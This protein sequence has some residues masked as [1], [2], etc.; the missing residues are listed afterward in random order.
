M[1]SYFKIKPVKKIL[2]FLSLFICFAPVKKSRAQL[3]PAQNVNHQTTLIT[4]INQGPKH[5]TIDADFVQ[6][7]TGKAAVAAAKKNGE[8]EFDINAK[9]DTSWYVSNDYYILNVNKKTRKLALAANANI[10]LVKEGSS[11]ITKSALQTLKRSYEGKL[12]KI[13]I[14]QKTVIKI[15]EIYTP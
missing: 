2:W 10:Y 9:G 6:M 1:E 5:I 15:E 11:K 12:F 7:L 14:K 8:A 4:A 3:N 13:L